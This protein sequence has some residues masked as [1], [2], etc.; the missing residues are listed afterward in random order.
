M[1]LDFP[2]SPI[3]GQQYPSPPIAGTPVWV[4]NGQ[5]WNVVV[6]G[7]TPTWQNRNRLINGNFIVD[8]RN[9]YGAL[10]PASSLFYTADRWRLDASQVSKLTFQCTAPISSFS[11]LAGQLNFWPGVTAT[12]TPGDYFTIN[13]LIEGQV[14]AFC[15]LLE[16]FL[17]DQVFQCFALNL[18]VLVMGGE[19]LC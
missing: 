3:V 14:L 7:S 15:L 19:K 4:W 18:I 8:Q 11:P 13:Q 12:I 6:T 17:V 16:Q 5:T 9:N 1:A 2:N 10:S